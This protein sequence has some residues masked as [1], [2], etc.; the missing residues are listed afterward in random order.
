MTRARTVVID[1]FPE[2]VRQYADGFAVVA[3]DVLRATTTAVTAVQQGRRCY[4]VASVEEATS[5]AARLARPLLVGE[6]GGE[7]P[8]EFDIDN[9]PARVHCRNDVE[10]PM[11]LLSTSGTRVLS[12]ARKAEVAYAA[13]LRNW[14]ATVRHLV[15]RHP[16]IAVIGA[17]T[18]GEFRE[19]DQLCCAWIA[20]ALL[21]RG[22]QARDERTAELVVRW[23]G[24]PAG[25]FDGNRSTEFL[26]SIGREDD[27]AFVLA[28][29][30]DIDQACRLVDGEL[31][32]LA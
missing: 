29:V 2:R 20:G 31:V 8:S 22:Y 1:C 5:L 3:V 13:C 11:V 26:R 4:P 23:R 16:H 19:E 15:E 12:E 17:G 7:V 10:R 14:S 32:A 18:R 24:L 9:S 30:D 25:A 21:D 28:H 27:L 6:L